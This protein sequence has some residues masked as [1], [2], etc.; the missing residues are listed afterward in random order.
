[1]I[2]KYK[3]LEWTELGFW[4]KARLFNKW[5]IVS[6]IGCL[7]L[8]F[9]SFLQ[10]VSKLKSISTTEL[11]LGFGCMFTWISFSRYIESVS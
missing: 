1:M 2:N 6:V 9:G 8:I 4:E 5:S 7:F 3:N 10:I 11:F